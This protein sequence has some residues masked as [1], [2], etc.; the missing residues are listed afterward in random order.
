MLSLAAAWMLI[1]G[2]VLRAQNGAAAASSQS[3]VPADEVTRESLK[4]AQVYEVLQQNYMS[5][6]DPDHLI[7][8]GAVRGMLSSLDPF[9]SFFDRDQFKT[10]QEETSGEA[11]GF[12]SILYVQPG[13]VMVIQTQQGSPSW[14]AGLGPGDQIM[15][16][17]GKL[18]S[19]LS[20]REL[21]GVLQQARSHPVHLSV[22][23]PG[24]GAAVDIRMS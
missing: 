15:A 12:G 13:K 14:R 20:F 21:I 5:P 8:E 2:C 24:G 10:L 4:F 17:N 9:S 11:L 18:L 22:L 3:D 1:G 23:H 7:L 19:R 16:V 6:L